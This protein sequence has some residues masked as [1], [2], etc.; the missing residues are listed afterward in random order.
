MSYHELVSH[1][2]NLPLSDR[3]ALMERIL[4]SIRQGL[5]AAVP[6]TETGED[7]NIHERRR[8]FRVRAFHLGEDVTVD[9]DEIYS[10]RGV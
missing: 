10:E 8:R 1:I 6:K 5:P 2:E 9:R 7:L 4:M 3:V